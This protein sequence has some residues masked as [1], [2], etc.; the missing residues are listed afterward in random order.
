MAA[1]AEGIAKL[2]DL[3]TLGNWGFL[4]YPM[5]WLWRWLLD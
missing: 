4:K 1:P 3:L 2:F 5:I